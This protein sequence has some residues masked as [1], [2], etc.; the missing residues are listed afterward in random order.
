M[1]TL[2]LL[3]GASAM[4]MTLFLPSLPRMA[5]DFAA[6]YALIQLAVAGYM[7][8]NAILQIFIG[9][10]ADR[11]G[12]RP[13]LLW[14]VAAFCLATLGCALATNVYVFLAFRM[15][16]SG[17]AVGLVLGRAVVRDMFPPDEAAAR[18]GYVTMG[19][20]LVP[21][22]APAFGGWLDETLGW[23]A[24]FWFLLLVGLLAARLGVNRM[25]MIGTSLTAAGLATALILN[26]ADLGG[27][28]VFF[29]G[30]FFVG[31]GN[32]LTMPSATSGMLS[33]RA[34]AS[35]LGGAIAIGSGATLSLIAGLILGPG[36]DEAPLIW[37]MFGTALAGLVAILL[38]IRRERQMGLT[39]R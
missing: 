14:G 2:V 10:F 29:G 33:V 23:R 12:R 24:A 26:L 34:P 27:V 38:V 6:T 31:M 22:M 8:T 3:T 21:M 16:Q 9:P 18:L 36:R 7:A 25:V 17:I 19:M 30:M 28:A 32:G 20:A 1:L 13:V 15:I 35:G 5:E 4:S 37:L 39:P 11:F